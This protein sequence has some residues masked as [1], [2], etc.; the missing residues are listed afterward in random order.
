MSRVLIVC[1]SSVTRALVVSLLGGEHEAH[2]TDSLPRAL[3]KTG[4]PPAAAFVEAAL[5]RASPDALDRLRA[6]WGH[7]FGVVLVD[8]AYS[9]E[10]RATDEVRAFG[11][12]AALA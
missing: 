7:P 2:P 11:A 4:A 3:E 1:A 5:V 12:S 8:R 6:A 9:D 10:R